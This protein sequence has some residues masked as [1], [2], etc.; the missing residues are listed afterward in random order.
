[1]MRSHPRSAQTGAGAGPR[2]L[3]LEAVRLQWN[4]YIGIFENP[5]KKVAIFMQK[6]ENKLKIL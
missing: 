5:E 2:Q 3:A 1:M 6:H 4:T